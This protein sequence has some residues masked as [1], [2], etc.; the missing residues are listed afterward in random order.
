MKKILVLLFGI[1]LICLAVQA[2]AEVIRY[3]VLF[4][5]TD[6]SSNVVIK[7]AAG[8]TMFYCDT[9]GN[10]TFAG[11]LSS[12]CQPGSTCYRAIQYASVTTSP[13]DCSTTPTGFAWDFFD[14]SGNHVL[15][16]G[17]T[18]SYITPMTINASGNYSL[19]SVEG[20]AKLRGT[21]F[22]VNVSTTTDAS[23]NLTG[24]S[25]NMSLV[26][27]YTKDVS[28]NVG[29]SSTTAN[30]YLNDPSGNIIGPYTNVYFT[31]SRAGMVMAVTSQYFDSSLR[32]V[33]KQVATVD[34]HN[35][36]AN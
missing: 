33:A 15:C 3:P 6:A 27:A 2:R 16:Q 24:P 23:V 29:I 5:T 7:N 30:I 1:A 17:T 28:K 10:C 35:L 22:Q 14:P 20:G 8:T 19:N 25:E 21:A 13:Y 11:D 26:I 9:S 12:T 18:K 31:E 4:I 34:G 32:W 36:T